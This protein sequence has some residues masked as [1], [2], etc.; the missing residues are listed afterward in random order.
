LVK[1]HVVYTLVL[2]VLPGDITTIGRA[3]ARLGKGYISVV[4]GIQE[5]ILKELNAVKKCLHEIRGKIIKEKQEEYVRVVSSHL[6]GH[7]Y[8]HRFANYMLLSELEDT[9]TFR[10][11]KGR[12]F[13][14]VASEIRKFSRETVSSS[15]KIH[16][17]LVQIQDAAK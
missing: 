13:E 7:Y 5:P 15:Q 1:K 3:D 2:R 6:K 4:F 17:K 11:N 9:N 14:V 10:H 8:T 16:E 12:G